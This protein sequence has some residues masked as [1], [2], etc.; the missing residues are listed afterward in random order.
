MDSGL[1]QE[2]ARDAQLRI[3]NDADVNLSAQMLC[4]SSVL[5]SARRHR[6]TATKQNSRPTKPF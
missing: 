4:F 6:D 5:S 1:A 3:G 2:R